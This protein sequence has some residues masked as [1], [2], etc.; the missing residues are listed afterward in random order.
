MLSALRGSGSQD[1]SRKATVTRFMRTGRPRGSSSAVHFPGDCV[2]SLLTY[3]E[4][5]AHEGCRRQNHPDR[6]VAKAL[7]RHTRGQERV[8]RP[9]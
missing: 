1:R 6:A 7:G 2:N 3:N 4:A 8:R 9:R 5:A